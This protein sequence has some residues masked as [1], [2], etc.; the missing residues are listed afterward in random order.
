MQTTIPSLKLGTPFQRPSWRYDAMTNPVRYG[1][2]DYCSDIQPNSGCIK[3]LIQK[4]VE[5]TSIYSYP[6]Y[7]TELAQYL[8]DEEN[9]MLQQVWMKNYRRAIGRKVTFND[10]ALERVLISWNVKKIGTIND[11]WFKKLILHA[12]NYKYD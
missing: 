8:T 7:F 3:R 11:E 5:P 12:F 9:E 10:Q 4:G 2:D 6:A 1:L